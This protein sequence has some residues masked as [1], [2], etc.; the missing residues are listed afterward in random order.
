MTGRRASS[1]AGVKTFTERGRKRSVEEM[2]SEADEADEP[3]FEEYLEGDD[4]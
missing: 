2:L 3:E 1:G 4:E